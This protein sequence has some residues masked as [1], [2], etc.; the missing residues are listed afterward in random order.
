MNKIYHIND[1]DELV[2]K[3]QFLLD[4]REDFEYE[5]GHISGATRISV[6]E[7]ENHLHELPKD[8][9]IYVYCQHGMRGKKAVNL[10]T[11][12]GF[13]AINLEEGY[14]TYTGKNSIVP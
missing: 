2:N 13:E 12:N 7:L 1:V 9:P 14:A 3:K 11:N 6:N 10:L 4:V 5:L 8:K